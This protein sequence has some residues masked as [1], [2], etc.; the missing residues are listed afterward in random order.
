MFKDS[1]WLI[2]LLIFAIIF[3]YS[4]K[5]TNKYLIEDTFGLINEGFKNSRVYLGE[6][7][8]KAH[9]IINM[10][11]IPFGSTSLYEIG[12]IEYPGTIKKGYYNDYYNGYYKDYYQDYYS[13]YI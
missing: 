5:N 1:H 2:I 6:T 3:Y 8:I 12:E 9:H 10:N 7:P 13:G 4:N 11:N